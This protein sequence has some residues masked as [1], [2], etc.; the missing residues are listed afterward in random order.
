MVARDPVP[1]YAPEL[2]PVEQV[3][4]QVKR[5][6]G[7]LLDS[8]VSM[9]CRGGEEP[10]RAHPVPTGADRRVPPLSV[11]GSEPTAR[12]TARNNNSPHP[13]PRSTIR[14]TASTFILSSSKSA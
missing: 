10:A 12:S 3:W 4:P 5:G 1:A 7:D 13:Q 9:S 14:V 11:A 8:G 2:N 6:L